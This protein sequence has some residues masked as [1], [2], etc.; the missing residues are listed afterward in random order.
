MRIVTQ[1]QTKGVMWGVFGLLLF[2]ALTICLTDFD[3]I[4]L[5][6]TVVFA[7]LI[8]NVR[9]ADPGRRPLS[10]LSNNKFLQG[11]FVFLIVFHLAHAALLLWKF[12]F[13]G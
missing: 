9:I 1:E 5:F 10:I 11:I 7:A 8:S 2:S 6:T 13:T 12:I 3:E 4:F